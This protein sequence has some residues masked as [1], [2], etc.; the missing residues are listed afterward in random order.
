MATSTAMRRLLALV[1]DYAREPASVDPDAAIRR[2]PRRAVSALTELADLMEQRARRAC[3]VSHSDLWSR[4]HL[5]MTG[6]AAS[7]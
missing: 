7:R 6:S 5:A 1:H 4:S 3:R 2:A